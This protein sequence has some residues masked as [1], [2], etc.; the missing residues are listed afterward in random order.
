MNY[1]KTYCI[2]QLKRIKKLLP[3]IAGMILLLA[4][5][6]GTGA[7][8]VIR[9][10]SYVENQKRYTLG[11]V[12]AADNSLLRSGVFLLENEDSAKEMIELK[13]YENEDDAKTALR[14][15]EISAYVVITKEFM[16]QLDALANGEKLKYYAT[17]GQKGITGVMMDEIAAVAG[18]IIVYTEKG[19][20]SLDQ[21]MEERGYEEQDRILQMTDCFNS[22]VDAILNRDSKVEI[23]SLGMSDGL[24]TP[25]YYFTTLMLFLFIMIPFCGI[26]FFLGQ[27]DAIAQFLKAKGLGPAR[28]VLAEMFAFYL[29]NIF[30]QLFVV[31]LLE[32]SRVVLKYDFATLLKI[33][34]QPYMLLPAMTLPILAFTAMGFFLLDAIQGVVNKVLVTFIIDIFMAYVAGFFYPRVFFPMEVQMLSNLLPSGAALTYVANQMVGGR[35]LEPAIVLIAYTILF[36]FL[37]I[38]VR[39]A[40]IKL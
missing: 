25:A 10:G 5:L 18:N 32:I 4:V 2:I 21:A 9:D 7:Y 24:S 15:G 27:R 6:F 31:I 28:Q 26:W 29:L 39:K 23:V 3:G 13:E 14:A 19:I 22:Y 37:S 16:G 11:Y 33:G 38:M 36:T 20:L 12:G 35:L 30:G 40:R 8:A 34:F 17:S 1:F